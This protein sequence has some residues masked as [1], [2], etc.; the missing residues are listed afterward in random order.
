M[1]I[2]QYVHVQQL[3]PLGPLQHPTSSLLRCARADSP[4]PSHAQRPLEGSLACAELCAPLPD[5]GRPATPTAMPLLP[6]GGRSMTS[7]SL[8]AAALIGICSNI[9]AICDRKKCSLDPWLEQ[10]QLGKLRN[11]ALEQGCTRSVAQRWPSVSCRGIR[12]GS[13]T[14]RF[15][16]SQAPELAKWELETSFLRAFS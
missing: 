3:A 6:L 7:M 4:R 14:F 9:S 1:M 2:V 8:L 10:F 5:L 15:F 11:V 13:F 16:S 12:S